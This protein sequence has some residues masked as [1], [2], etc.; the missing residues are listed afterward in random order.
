MGFQ[1]FEFCQAEDGCRIFFKGGAGIGND[2][3][4]FEEILHAQGRG[5]PGGAGRGQ[6]VIGPGEIVTHGFRSIIAEKYGSGMGDLAQ[7]RPGVEDLELQVFRSN[8]VGQFDGDVKVRDQEKGPVVVEGLPGDL[9]SRELL[10]L[11]VAD[12]AAS[13]RPRSFRL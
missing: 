9:V 1:T 11:P 4:A 5:E 3:G 10:Q 7:A 6:D 2:A 13:Y 12:S 8:P